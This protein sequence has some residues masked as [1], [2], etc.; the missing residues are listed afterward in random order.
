MSPAAAPDK[1][2]PYRQG[3]NDGRRGIDHGDHYFGEDYQDY[4]DGMHDGE[5]DDCDDELRGDED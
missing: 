4:V 3:F 5:L 2:S 1:P